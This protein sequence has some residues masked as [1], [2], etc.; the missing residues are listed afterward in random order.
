MTI[1]AN[2]GTF[3]QTRLVQQVQT[4]DNEIVTAFQVASKKTLDPSAETMRQLHTG[5]VDAVNGGAG[6]AHQAN[7]ENV[8]SPGKRA[9]RNGARRTRNGRPP[10]SQGSSRRNTR[11]MHSR[12]YTRATWAAR[13]TA[14]QQPRR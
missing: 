8:R 3:Y 13:C 2:G 4:V 7:L 10:G 14:E 9:P 5:M 1:V 12:P 11:N 6:T